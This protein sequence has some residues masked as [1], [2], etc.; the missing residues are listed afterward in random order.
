MS[1]TPVLGIVIPCYNEQE[2]IE[3]SLRSLLNLLESFIQKNRISSESF[4][5]IVD[6]RS[7]D[8]T[9]TIITNMA[10]GNG[11]IKA[12]RLAAN[13]G[14]QYAL[15]AGLLEYGNLADCVISMDADLQDDVE[16]IGEM[17][18]RY[19]QGF[20]IVYGVRKDR[21]TDSFFKRFS[22]QVFYRFQK[23]LNGDTIYNHADFRLTSRK[24]NL[25]LKKYAEVNIYL[26]GIFPQM[27][28]NTAIVYYTRKERMAGYTKYPL[29]KMFSLALDGITSFSTIPLRV[30]TVVGFLVFIFC[31]FLMLY[32]FV[33]FVKHNTI[34]GWFST[35]LPFYFLGGIQIL[36]IGILGEYLGKIYK[37]VKRRPRFSI[38][39]RIP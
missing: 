21:S 13:R 36:C 27:G 22:A 24:V 18:D 39:E 7:K 14:H 35:V 32:A 28:F 29:R 1:E 26:R 17:I 16:I 8:A 38:D 15:L 37:E 2:V 23:F 9:W 31:I 33:S 30:I 25:E 12:I 34:P 20:Q 10:K 4:L 19:N 5:G 3:T 6:D 11:R